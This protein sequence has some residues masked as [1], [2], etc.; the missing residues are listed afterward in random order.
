M[1]LISY[2]SEVLA[3]CRWS[4]YVR[5]SG[6][7]CSFHACYLTQGYTPSWEF[8][9]TLDLEWDVIRGRRSYER[10]FW[11]CNDRPFVPPLLSEADFLDR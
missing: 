9:I 3:R 10:V 6:T 7:G 2:A 11:V 4:L 1:F 8:L 5:P